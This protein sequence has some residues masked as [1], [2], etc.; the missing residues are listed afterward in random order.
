VPYIALTL[1]H[2]LILLVCVFC[3]LALSLGD[4]CIT[5]QPR[6]WDYCLGMFGVLGWNNWSEEP[7]I[8]RYEYC[9]RFSRA[10]DQLC[11]ALCVSWYAP[12]YQ[13]LPVTHNRNKQAA[14]LLLT[15]LHGCCALNSTASIS[16]SYLYFIVIDKMF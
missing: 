2:L 9:V 13:H 12:W 10:T 11:R 7:F 6:S 15:A 8:H 1:I 14:Q 5:L 4:N 16:F 3:C